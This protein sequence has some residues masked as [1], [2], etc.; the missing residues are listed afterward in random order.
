MEFQLSLGKFGLGIWV[1]RYVVER[2]TFRYF[3]VAVRCGWR[4][5]RIELYRERRGGFR[6]HIRLPFINV[7]NDTVQK[8]IDEGEPPYSIRRIVPVVSGKLFGKELNN[9]TEVYI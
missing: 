9:A 8:V 3:A 1:C 2:A 4:E 7:G 5:S 6:F